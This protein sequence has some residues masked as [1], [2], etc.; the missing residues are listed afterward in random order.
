MGKI[1]Q[2][3]VRRRNDVTVRSRKTT[4]RKFVRH[5]TVSREG[6][7]Q[8]KLTNTWNCHLRCVISVDW[9]DESL[10]DKWRDDGWESPTSSYSSPCWLCQKKCPIS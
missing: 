7:L 8:S 2:G 4:F 9:K 5:K 10:A 6:P 3:P 1:A